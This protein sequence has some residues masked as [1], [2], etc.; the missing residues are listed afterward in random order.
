MKDMKLR[1]QG[2]VLDSRDARPSRQQSK[3]DHL[4]MATVTV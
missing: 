1:V 3:T 2:M 4:D